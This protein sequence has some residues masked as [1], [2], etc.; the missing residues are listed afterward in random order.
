M[1]RKNAT[2]ALIDRGVGTMAA[3]GNRVGRPGG[4]RQYGD[5]VLRVLIAMFGGY[6]VTA[7]CT[8]LLARV[9]PAARLDASLWATILSFALYA[10]L[11]VWTFAA[12]SALRAGLVVLALGLLAGLGAALAPALGAA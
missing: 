6:A 11:V 7:A 5:V 4:A 10:A 1:Y 9:L 2:G 12:S 8:M 3:T